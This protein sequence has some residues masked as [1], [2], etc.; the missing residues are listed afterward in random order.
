MRPL[1]SDPRVLSEAH[2]RVLAAAAQAQVR[3]GDVD[4]RLEGGTALSAYY[5]GH[6]ES[7]DLDLLG[8]RGLHAGE[9]AAVL[10]ELLEHA[11]QEARV[12]SGGA[13][14]AEL[15][16]GSVR[17]HVARTSPF[18][19]EAP[20]PTEE[21]LPVASLRDL[22]AGK[23]HALCDRFEVRDYVD[24]H[25]ILTRPDETGAVPSADAQR[26]R[27]RSLVLDVLA[28]DPGLNPTIV[29][30]ALARGLDRPLIGSF[31]LRVFRKIA[32]HEMQTTLRIAVEACARL[33]R[34]RM[35]A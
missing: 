15:D 34:E 4:L 3:Y 2:R 17:V 16:A 9:F 27:A 13:G 18:R 22:A 35:N 26:E 1:R 8:S 24:V 31:P 33:A 5:L 19:P 11:G 21:G 32:E 6:R 28:V 23:L 14:F 25:A 30:Q 10:S 29:G 20:V 12:V 7:E